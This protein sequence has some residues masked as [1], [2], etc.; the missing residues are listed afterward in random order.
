[1]SSDKERKAVQLRVLSAGSGPNSAVPPHPVFQGW[2]VVRLDIDPRVQPDIVADVVNL[3]TAVASASFNAVWTSHNIEHLPDH[4]VPKALSEFKRVLRPD[5]FLFVTTP[6]LQQLARSIASGDLDSVLYQSPAG[7]IAALD[8]LFGHRKSIERGYGFMAHRTGFTTTRLGQ[9][10]TR[11]GFKEV[12][13]GSGSRFD[14]WAI[15]L[16]ERTDAALLKKLLLGTP[17]AFLV[18]A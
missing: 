11:A 8:I 16:L 6:D 9:L 7:P 1:M 18:R 2:H 10:M 3:Q 15:G 5:G 4:D 12:W 13:V 17:Q 14:L